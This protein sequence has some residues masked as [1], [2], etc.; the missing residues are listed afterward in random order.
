MCWNASV[1]LNTFLIG[2]I[3]IT[4]GVYS[5]MS[6]PVAFFCFSIALI[7]LIEY[8]VWTYY[9]NKVVNYWASV[10]ASSLLWVQPIASISMVGNA[11]LRNAMLLSYGLLSFVG[12]FFEKDKK[13]YSMTRAPNG[14]LSWNWM[15][16][17]SFSKLVVYMIFLFVPIFITKNYDIAALALGTLGVSIYSYWRENTWGSMWCWIANGLVL[18]IIGQQIS[19]SI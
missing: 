13:N 16:P 2:I 19:T 12:Q 15:K 11:G 7:Q 5:G 8:F 9:D 1:S 3:G 14:H 18:M 4:I 17:V 10:A 6:L